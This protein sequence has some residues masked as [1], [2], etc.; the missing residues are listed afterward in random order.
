EIVKL[1]FL[2][3]NAEE[4]AEP[5]AEV[6]EE[7]VVE[8]AE[9]M[10]VEEPTAESEENAVA[11]TDLTQTLVFEDMAEQIESELQPV[12][13]IA[14]ELQTVALTEGSQE[15]REDFVEQNTKEPA[16]E[17]DQEVVSEVIVEEKIE[18][19]A[20]AEQAE[21]IKLE[22]LTEQPVEVTSEIEEEV[23]AEEAT[24]EPVAEIEEVIA[25]SIE[26][27]SSDLERTPSEET[28]A[29]AIGE[30]ISAQQ[31][32]VD[33]VF[34][35]LIASLE[36]L[37]AQR[38][39]EKEQ[40]GNI[41][42]YSHVFAQAN[43]RAIAMDTMQA[44]YLGHTI[45][46]DVRNITDFKS[47]FGGPFR[48]EDL[49]TVED[50]KP[51]ANETDIEKEIKSEDP[52]TVE[53]TEQDLVKGEQILQPEQIVIPAVSEEKLSVNMA[54]EKKEPQAIP[55]HINISGLE[56]ADADIIEN[57][58]ENI[59]LSIKLSNKKSKMVVDDIK[60]ERQIEEAK[61]TE[62]KSVKEENESTSGMPKFISLSGAPKFV[63]PEVPVVEGPRIIAGV[64]KFMGL[65]GTPK[66]AGGM[67][68]SEEIVNE[69]AEA[70]VNEEVKEAVE[71]IAVESKVEEMEVAEIKAKEITVR[72]E[73]EATV[74]EP[75]AVIEAQSAEPMVQSLPYE[76]QV[77]TA[78]PNYVK[79]SGV[80]SFIEPPKEEIVEIEEAVSEIT[81]D[82][83]VE[84]VFTIPVETFDN[85]VDFM[86]ANGLELPKIP[87]VNQNMGATAQYTKQE[88][89]LDN[90]DQQAPGASQEMGIFC[91][92]Q[93]EYYR[94]QYY[95]LKT[96]VDFYE[97]QMGYY[98]KQLSVSESQ[99]QFYAQQ[100]DM[101][102]KQAD[103][104]RVK[105]KED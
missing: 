58:G 91:N 35:E 87:Q 84:S 85:P 105:K 99:L 64:P 33:P 44:A 61:M 77:G 49:P 97:K 47:R 38:V 96:Q 78:S 7:E 53:N 17:T 98:Q 71:D 41:V 93:E 62:D 8:A 43:E 100:A 70:V 63:A 55:L 1:D 32:E 76:P 101:Y 104:Y 27:A 23:V 54:K 103:F 30:E 94:S 65:P 95:F 56:N 6:A 12:A 14:K 102:L 50:Q 86:T 34:E 13:E 68:K 69:P 15:V 22:S 26:Q 59:I 20:I 42:D 21:E 3:P 37:E 19:E 28:P 2:E 46:Y 75:V 88:L 9:E 36:K 74:E 31:E 4:S 40:R 66:F 92:E 67:I 73:P 5:V 90:E 24:E 25:E 29:A 60:V 52:V 80:P 51:P 45:N 39:E 89:G 83:E 11:K 82:P 79:I 57:D 81:Q 48:T 18:E 72:P 16:A 10:I